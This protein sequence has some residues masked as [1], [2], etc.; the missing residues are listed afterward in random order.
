VLCSET[1]LSYQ[2]PHVFI[3]RRRV[4]MNRSHLCPVED[5]ICQSMLHIV[6]ARRLA[7]ALELRVVDDKP[8][9]RFACGHGRSL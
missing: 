2:R 1:T 8:G 5:A 6:K 4:Q 9:L 3:V 7:R